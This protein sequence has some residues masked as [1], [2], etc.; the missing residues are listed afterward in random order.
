MIRLYGVEKGNSSWPR[1][2]HG[3]RDGLRACGALGG[4]YDVQRV[5][6]DDLDDGNALEPGHDTPTALCIG[7]PPSASVM[8]GRG[9]HKE[10][11]LL[12]ATNSSWL[13]E[14]M[15][16]RAA[17]L[18]TGFVAP[19]AWSAS[20]I[21]RYAHGLPVYVYQHGVDEGFCVNHQLR[22]VVEEPDS[23]WTVLHLASTH[24]QR[25][26]TRELILGW[27]EAMRAGQIPR[28]ARIRMIVDGP[29]GHFLSVIAEASEGN[30]EI[31]DSYLLEMRKSFTVKDM[32]A[33]YGIHDFVCQPSRGEGFGMVPLEARACGV[34]VIATACTGHAE[35]IHV[36]MP[37]VVVIPAGPERP[38]DDGPGALAP[39]VHPSDIAAALH[40]AFVNSSELTTKA[41]VAAA[42][43]RDAWSWKECTAR[44]LHANPGLLEA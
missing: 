8:V 4:F 41:A 1:V 17:K 13:P 5:D 34:P 6:G 25:K 20:V 23:S 11:L 3:V 37:G 29:R 10:R 22:P 30:T 7:S 18:C 16:E 15:M 2:T 31:A 38:V 12:I 44:F 35:H 42:T 24:M 32:A 43:V 26:G 33:L 19:S 21:E 14:V 28:D 40:F 39:A 9:R 36:G 27:A